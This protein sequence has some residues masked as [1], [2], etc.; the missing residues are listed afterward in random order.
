MDKSDSV[1]WLQ[2]KMWIGEDLKLI[3]EDFTDIL[4]MEYFYVWLKKSYGGI[5]TLEELERCLD[6]FWTL[7]ERKFTLDRHVIDLLGNNYAVYGTWYTPRRMLESI[8]DTPELK[9][10]SF[11]NTVMLIKIIRDIDEYET[12]CNSWKAVPTIRQLFNVLKSI[13]GHDIA[14]I[15]LTKLE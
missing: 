11:Q 9:I 8:F 4:N 13:F 2:S 12:F 3:E 1:M 5:W 15:I 6:I 7:V 10:R 14:C